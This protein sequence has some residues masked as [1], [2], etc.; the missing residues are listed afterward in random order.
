MPIRPRSWLQETKRPLVP[1][2]AG[3]RRHQD[4]ADARRAPAGSR[5][6]TLPARAAAVALRPAAEHLREREH[7][8]AAATMPIA[9]QKRAVV[10]CPTCVATQSS[11]PARPAASAVVRPRVASYSPYLRI[12]SPLPLDA[13]G[14]E[15]W[16]G[17][18]D[19]CAIRAP[20]GGRR[21]SPTRARPGTPRS[22]RGGRPG[23]RA[24]RPPPRGRCGTGGRR[25]RA[26]TMFTDVRRQA[27]QRTAR[28]SEPSPGASTRNDDGNTGRG[29]SSG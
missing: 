17:R 1:A 25:A 26:E 24:R 10:C 9:A 14:R 29:R 15:T 4:P 6:G 12:R 2:V 20:A 5:A 13:S 27:G 23:R 3:L 22:R 18:L 21:S 8:P 11:S 28:P 16:K 7:E 19:G